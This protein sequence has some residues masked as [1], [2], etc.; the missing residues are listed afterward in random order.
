MR[1]HVLDNGH[2]ARTKTLKTNVRMISL[3]H[4][5]FG[6]FFELQYLCFFDLQIYGNMIQVNRVICTEVISNSKNIMRGNCS[7]IF[8][9]FGF[10]DHYNGR[11]LKTV[12]NASYGVLV[13]HKITSVKFFQGSVDFFTKDIRSSFFTIGLESVIP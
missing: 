13:V 8:E 1:R 3:S 4:N 6:Y 2:K 7:N 11:S 10:V 12:F 5:M 9:W